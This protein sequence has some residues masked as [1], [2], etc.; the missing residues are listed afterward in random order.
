MKDQLDCNVV[1]RMKRTRKSIETSTDDGKS[2]LLSNCDNDK[3]DLPHEKKNLQAS[4]KTSAKEK[5]L[6]DLIKPRVNGVQD[7]N[8]IKTLLQEVSTS[9]PV[10]CYSFEIICV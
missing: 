9:P 10:S 3:N 1:V 4:T 5:I 6:S 8:L 7:E 2:L